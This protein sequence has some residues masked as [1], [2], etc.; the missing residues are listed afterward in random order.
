MT[1]NSLKNPIHTFLF[2]FKAGTIGGIIAGVFEVLLISN[3]GSAPANFSGLLF[4]VVAYGIL[5][6]LIGLG[7]NIV[8]QLLPIHKER[9]RD[10]VFLGAFIASASISAVLF[11]IL[12]FRAFRDFHA[13]RV[14][15][16]EPTG[17]LTIAVLLAGG[18]ILFLLFR[19]LLIRPLKSV[20]SWILKP[21]GYVIV[22]ASVLVLGLIL[23]A[24]LAKETEA[25]QVPFD[26]AGQAALADKPSVI[27][28]M[29]D[30]LRRDRV[31]CYGDS[32]AAATPN[33]DA[34][35]A[36]GAVF[37]QVY[38]QA[39]HT[40][41]ST[42]T[43]LSSRY[44]TEHRAIHKTDALPD[45]V[46]T[47]PEILAGEGYYCGGIVTN[48][49]LAP[50]YNFQHGFHEYTYLPPKFFF[51]ANE[52]ASRSVVYGV[53]RLIR[54][55]IVQNKYVYHFY[56]SG[57][58]VTGYYDDFLERNRDKTF[59]LFLHYMDPH[60]PYFEHTYSGLGYARA[61]MPNP[62]PRFVEP[63]KEF[64]RQDTEYLDAW[65][66]EVINKLK[67][68]ELYDN[69]L[70]VLTSDHGEEFYEHGGW[71]HGTTLH[72]E[73]VR[74]PLI[75][76]KP[77]SEGAGTFIETLCGLIDVPP[78]ILGELGSELPSDMRGR[79][80]FETDSEG[81]FMS[82]IFSEADHEGNVVQMLR[83]GSWKYIRTNSDNPRR[84]PAQQLFYLP[85]D[86]GETNNLVETESAKAEEMEL[87]LKAKYQDVLAGR[88]EGADMEI[89]QATQ[90]R[91]RAL[92]YTQ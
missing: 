54:M 31:S 52:A 80:L 66:A 1:G 77:A 36:D 7:K 8:A 69:S 3:F 68:L 84:R 67:N 9:K 28:I 35:A 58:T 38:S 81:E 34:L 60:D 46:T 30:T 63:F 87:L 53:L 44:P 4:S 49:N 21:F 22:V 39:T 33:I 14:R 70:I 85:D 19:L 90:E 48:I 13:E 18:F 10:R 40:K 26:N 83:V 6:G 20:L 92:G 32:N 75:I 37:D 59:F 89:D 78:M 64:Y 57:E 51:G 29:V 72:E 25:V 50:I 71:W 11:L 56:R 23:N 24:S 41:P 82:E 47:L 2:S 42:A 74:V 15:F 61:A 12:I 45:G 5:G 88:V 86:P 91:L 27:L 43:L 16:L 76:K 73:Q 62:D 79:D 17:L 65:I 55:K